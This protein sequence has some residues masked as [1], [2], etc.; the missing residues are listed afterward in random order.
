MDLEMRRKLARQPFE[1]K[2][3]LVGQLI[4][5]SAAVKSSRVR[6]VKESGSVGKANGGP[7]RRRMSNQSS[8]RATRT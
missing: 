8:D 6:E 5:L 2:I 7:D 3:R 1:Q 4:Q